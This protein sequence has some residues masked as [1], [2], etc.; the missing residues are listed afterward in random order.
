MSVSSLVA[1]FDFYAS[2]D[3]TR[4]NSKTIATLFVEC[5][6]ELNLSELLKLGKF[7][8]NVEKLA[9]VLCNAGKCSKNITQNLNY[10]DK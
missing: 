3:A 5:M 10:K 4:C 8:I 7:H 1:T 2:I 9:H 6:L